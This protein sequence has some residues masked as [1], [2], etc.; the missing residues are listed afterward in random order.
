MKMK[1]LKRNH[2]LQHPLILKYLDG[3]M[4]SIVLFLLMQRLETTITR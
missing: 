2:Q 1:R 4:T 3:L